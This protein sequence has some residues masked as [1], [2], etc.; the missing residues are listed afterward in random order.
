MSKSVS[1]VLSRM[2]IY[3]WPIVA[4]RFLRPTNRDSSGQ[5]PFSVPNLVLLRMGFTEPTSR[6]VAGELLPHLSTLT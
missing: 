3:L 2:I 4:N 5:L 6:L 1:R